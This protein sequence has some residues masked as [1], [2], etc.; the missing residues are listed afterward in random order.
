MAQLAL[1]CFATNGDTVGTDDSTTE[2]VTE[3]LATV[4][5]LADLGRL[6]DSL[7]TAEEK[8]LMLYR[9]SRHLAKDGMLDAVVLGG[10]TSDKPMTE[11]M[12][13]YSMKQ[14]SEVLAEASETVLYTVGNTDYIAGESGDYNS[15]DYYNTV[16]ADR[17]G[18]LY[19]WD[20]YYETYNGVKFPTAYRYYVGGV[21]FYFLNTAPSD[22][23]GALHY[24]NFVY[25]Q[26]AM[27]W[28]EDKM[29]TD[30]PN[31]DATM[32]LVA[33]F[34]PEG[35]GTRVGAL[36]AAVS[37]RLTQICTEH[38]NLIYLYANTDAAQTDT[39]ETVI[40]FTNEG[41]VLTETEEESEGL[42]LASLWTVV[43]CGENMVALQNG[44]N[45]HYLAI[46]DGVRLT[47][48]DEPAAWI[49]E[50]VNGR[51]SFLAADRV[52]GLR[53]AKSGTPAFSLGTATP[54]EVY[55]R[56]ADE[57]GTLYTYS[58]DILPGTDCAIVSD[59]KH[60]LSVSGQ[61]VVTGEARVIGDELVGTE[62]KTAVDGTPGFTAVSMGTVDEGGET[63]QYLTLSVYSDRVELQLNNYHTAT[64]KITPLNAFVRANLPTPERITIPSTKKPATVDPFNMKLYL[65]VMAGAI[66]VGGGIGTFVT[67]RSSRHRFFE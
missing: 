31:G 14:I 7:E 30:D 10:D 43:S 16:M 50:T 41:L 57:E 17:L 11:E 64:E 5:C 25:T 37:E 47:L 42:G 23:A 40:P 13:R 3:P 52:N 21:Y 51:V 62:P 53:V 29:K 2:P 4:A 61:E 34:P 59:A 44:K 20:F 38:A 1:P 48:S 35:D 28:I 39:A 54:M 67:V 18:T 15:G 12:W 56:S 27:S 32:F 22:M 60:V 33:H 26:R 49:T 9:F 63:I 19:Y 66:L 46:E 55:I 6:A 24:G 65:L 58:A 45:G 8:R 36:E